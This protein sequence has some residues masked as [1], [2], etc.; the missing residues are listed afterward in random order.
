M[1][2]PRISPVGPL[3]A[4]ILVVGEC[5]TLEDERHMIAFSS[6]TAAELT[7]MLHEAGFIKADLRM[8]YICDFRPYMNKLSNVCTR[9]KK[10]AVKRGLPDQ[11]NGWYYSSEMTESFKR[12]DAEIERLAPT[13]IIALGD[14]ALWHLTGEVSITKWRGSILSTKGGIKV[15][16]TM[17][18][19]SVLRNWEYRSMAVRDLQRAKFESEFPEIRTPEY[20]FEIRPSFLAASHTLEMLLDRARNQLSPLRIAADIETIGRNIACIGFAWSRTSA[21]CIPIMDFSGAFYTESEEVALVLLIRDL[22]TH[23]NVEVVWQNGAYDSQHIIRHW[24]FRPNLTHDTM[25]M[26]HTAFPGVPKDLG[27]LSSMYCSHH[28]YWKDELTDYHRMPEDTTKFWTYNA[29]DCVNT[30]EIA[31]TLLEVLEHLRLMP[32]YEF[33]MRVLH[34]VVSIMVRGVN[35][36]QAYKAQLAFDLLDV[37]AERQTKI[38]DLLG[39]DLNLSSPKQMA[40]LFYTEM[41]FKPVL[42]KKTFQP[43]LDDKALTE[44]AQREPLIKPLVETISEARSI[45]VFLSTFVQMPLDADRRMRC[46]FNVGGTET[47]RFSSSKDA[48]GSGGNLQNIPKGDEDEDHAPGDFVL[49]NIR[50]LFLPDHGIWHPKFDHESETFSGEQTYSDGVDIFDVD[51]AGADAQVVAWE[52]SDDDLK[53]KFRSG[54]KIHALN[55]KDIFGGDAGPDGKKEPYYSRAKMGVH[56]TNYGGNARTCAKATGQTVHEAERFQNRWFAMHPGIR[57][58]HERTLNDL[59]TKRCVTNKFGYRRFYF[60]R[61]DRLLP[62]ALA[63][64][65]QSTI[66]FVT[67][68]GLVNIS[69]SGLPIE[70]LLQVHDS[71]IGQFPTRYRYLLLPKLRELLRVTIPYDDP[72]IISSGLKLSTKS[73]GDCDNYA[74]PEK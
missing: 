25:L 43:T 51:L 2:S 9:V 42:H 22:L 65:P 18:P 20:A 38:F 69:E 24:G 41:Q 30:W 3:D 61:M 46:S 68:H 17:S 60:G 56:L 54:M 67:H 71:L 27:F 59:Y 55:A 70:L 10:D 19:E 1:S 47:Y 33:L 8:A 40:Q 66:A 6:P 29:K 53:A 31:E 32:Q 4:R 50:R 23:P 74:W 52:A 57:E 48:F 35:I 62:E 73:W 14:V 5:P 12:L 36:D 45:G 28:V 21:I 58:W 49:P 15:I 26:Q 72:L 7:K 16:P 44:L 64:I 34:H 63:W 37:L 11:K 13:L 39:F